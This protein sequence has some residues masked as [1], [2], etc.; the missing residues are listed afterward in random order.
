MA[1]HDRLGYG[2]KVKWKEEFSESINITVSSEMY[3][4]NVFNNT[5]YEEYNENIISK[6]VDIIMN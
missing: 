3:R 2:V 5:M 4:N 1:N 6:L